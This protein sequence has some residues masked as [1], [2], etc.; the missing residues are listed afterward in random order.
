MK[1]FIINLIKNIT[2]F[3]FAK[4]K[5]NKKDVEKERIIANRNVWND[6]TLTK[7]DQYKHLNKD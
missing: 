5:E 1:I 3:L 6:P 2:S 4:N 7:L